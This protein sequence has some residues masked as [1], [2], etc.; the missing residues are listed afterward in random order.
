MLQER[1]AGAGE[2]RVIWRVG[3]TVRRPVGRQTAAVHALL[4]HLESVGFDGAPRVHGIDDEGREV[5]SFVEGQEG[6][7]VRHGEQTL[8]QVGRLVRRFHEAVAGFRPPPDAVWR[9]TG[10]AEGHAGSDEGLAGPTI[11]CHG[12]LARTTRSTGRARRSRSSTGTSPA[13]HRPWSMWRTRRG[14]SSLS[15]RTRSVCESAF[16]WSRAGHGS[17]SSATGTDCGSG[18]T[19]SPISARICSLMAAR[20]LRGAS[21]SS[22]RRGWSGMPTLSERR[23]VERGHHRPRCSG[24]KRT[25]G[26]TQMRMTAKTRKMDA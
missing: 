13:R 19:S 22:T 16:R 25:R 6:R 11:V 24:T 5:L 23:V 12:D 2:G 1:L 18:P 17:G 8:A 10:S 9:P 14:R 4:R 21:P 26:V 15:T 3:D 7:Q 20:P